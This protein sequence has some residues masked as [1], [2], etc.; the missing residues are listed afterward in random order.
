MKRVAQWA[1]EVRESLDEHGLGDVAGLEGV[2]LTLIHIESGG[3]PS[4]RKRHVVSE[5][6]GLLQMGRLAGIDV[7]FA[8]RGRRTTSALHG[9]GAMAIQKCAEYL[10]RYRGR[11][12]YSSEVPLVERVAACWKGG[13][14][15]ARRLR[16][17]SKPWDE[18]LRWLQTHPNS[19]WRIPNLV[20]YVHRARKLHPHWAARAPVPED[21][22]PEADD[23]FAGLMR[24]GRALLKGLV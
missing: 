17:S 9:N 1:D 18:S 7:G 6:Y 4:A 19:A 13:P 12:D 5:Y 23:L 15:T 16:S 11:W 22:A 8:D 3:N 20:Q 14:G 24:V 21:V 10:A 2:I